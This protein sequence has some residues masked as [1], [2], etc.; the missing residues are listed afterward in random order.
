MSKQLV[1]TSNTSSTPLLVC[2]SISTSS[3]ASTAISIPNLLDIL[4]DK[5][6]PDSKFSKINFL[7]FLIEKHCI[8]NYEFLTQLNSILLNYEFYS[9][10]NST[11]EWFEVYSKYIENG[12]IN[13]RADLVAN[14]SKMKLPCIKTLRK[15]EKVIINYLLDSYYEFINY[16]GVIEVIEVSNDDLSDETSTDYSSI[17]NASASECSLSSTGNKVDRNC[18]PD[19]NLELQS[20]SQPTPNTSSS[21]LSSCHTVHSTTT[22]ITTSP[23]LSPPNPPAAETPATPSPFTRSWSDKL[24]STT[25][26]FKW[27]RRTS[28]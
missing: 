9:K 3:S 8:E 5:V 23:P 17:C 27:K 4:N 10:Y 14:L 1:E 28:Y 7:T 21:E 26:K 6:D 24:K 19:P 15:I 18:L 22:A 25:N 13:L 20:I 11:S 2:A 12:V 16:N